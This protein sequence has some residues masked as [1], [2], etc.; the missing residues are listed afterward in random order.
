[1]MDEGPPV[2]Q[3][4]ANPE[5]R[6]QTIWVSEFSDSP[7][8]HSEGR[9][10]RV[11]VQADVQRP[12]SLVTV[13]RIPVLITSVGGRTNKKMEALNVGNDPIA[14]ATVE[15]SLRPGD[16]RVTTEFAPGQEWLFRIQ[17]K[18]PLLDLCA[19]GTSN[20]STFENRVIEDREGR[21]A[22]GEQRLVIQPCC[23]PRFSQVAGKNSYALG[24]YLPMGGEAHFVTDEAEWTLCPDQYLVVNPQEIIRYADHQA[25]PL[26]FRRLVLDQPLLRRMREAI[27]F[28]QRFGAFGFLPGPRR[29]GPGLTRAIEEWDRAWGIQGV[30]RRERLESIAQWIFIELLHEHANGL[31]SQFSGERK[32]RDPR[33]KM[34]LNY[35]AHHFT[36][37]VTERQV[38]KVVGMSEGWVR[39]RFRQAMGMSLKDEV[40]RLRMERAVQL[41]KDPSKN[42][43]EV[44]QAVGYRNVRFFYEVFRAYA[45]RNPRNPLSPLR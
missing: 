37:P 16:Y 44:A 7:A 31:T 27:G 3:S 29:M 17:E 6:V 12:P 23:R 10:V 39:L 4:E 36:E 22:F 8:G 15:A 38:A 45:R 21:A 20:P 18:G 41:L 28:P 5:I 2:S 9:R 14:Q 1:M 26:R 35:L 32:T 24:V 34:V 43:A 19:D 11:T 25:W 33:L 30:G 40:Q 13:V 42:V